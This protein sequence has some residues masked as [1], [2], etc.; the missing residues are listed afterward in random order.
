MAYYLMPPDSAPSAIAPSLARKE[1][2]I[3]TLH[4]PDSVHFPEVNGNNALSAHEGPAEMENPT[5]LP[6]EII[7]QF[8]FTFLI[9]HPKNSI[10][11]YMRC[12]TPPL[13]EVTGFL[14]F[15]PSE[16]GYVE[17]RRLFDY[18]RSISDQTSLTGAE[19][20]VIDADGMWFPS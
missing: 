20:C 6:K 8:H 16:A 3:G 5:I 9:R 18:C 2:G 15:M 17:L 12:T 7:S 11:S 14:G 1:R 10:P 4:A 13:N 19:I